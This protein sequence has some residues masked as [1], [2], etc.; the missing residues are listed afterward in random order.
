M[1]LDFVLLLLTS[2]LFI[3]L[4]FQKF[5]AKY[6]TKS[7]SEISLQLPPGPKKLPFIGNLHLL[8]SLPHRAF[9]DL[10]NK[11]GP[12]MHLQLG[13][14]SMIVVSSPET[15]KEVMQTQDLNFASRPS[16]IASDIIAYNSSNISFSPHGDYWRQLR[17][18]YT[19]ELSGLTRVHSFRSLREEE[20][21]NLIRRIAGN[22]GSTIDLTQEIHT[23][24]YTI[25]SRAS[26]GNKSKYLKEFIYTIQEFIKSASGFNIADVYPSIKFLHVIGG[27]NSKLMN[28]HKIT[29]KLLDAIINERRTGKLLDQTNKDFVDVL[30]QY[31]REDK[32]LEFSMTMDNIKAVLLDIFL[33]GSGSSAKTINWTMSEMMK[34]PKI[35]EK[36]QE[37]ITRVF[38][39][40]SHVD[41]ACF[42]K[43]KYLKSVIKETLRLHPPGPLLLPRVSNENCIINGYKIPAKIKVIV[44]AWAINRHPSYWKDAETFNPDR[45]L[46]NPLNYKGTHFEYIPFGAGR[47]MCPGIQFGTVNVELTLAKLLY[48]FDWKLPNGMK[49]E[50]LNMTEDASLV[51]TRKHDLH[52]IP[53]IKYP[54]LGLND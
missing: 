9:R 28:C 29:D 40:R 23:S 15:A 49:P 48:H 11:Y 45:F 27:M 25:S 44:N 36:A 19:L 33:A 26:F 47:R 20:A 5:R 30:L 17:K 50:D 43:L 16:I 7:S 13:E 34:N 22:A 37:E 32:N 41:E 3:T 52:L 51:L 6:K 38:G 12:I 42:D 1:D 8:G 31:F 21:S 54:L 14:V 18:I 46:E 53:I 39:E 10:A 35:M 2:A 24:I 4:L